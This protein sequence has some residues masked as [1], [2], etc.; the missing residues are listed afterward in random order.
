[1]RTKQLLFIALTFALSTATLQAQQLS[2]IGMAA[3]Y[4]DKLHGKRTAAGELYDKFALTAAHYNL[5]VGSRILVTR[6]DN[7][8]SVEVRVNDCCIFTKGRIV[9]LSRAAAE[10]IDLIKAGTAQVR[11]DVISV[12]DGRK[13]GAATPPAVV[14]AAAPPKAYSAEGEKLTPKGAAPPVPT[15]TYRAEELLD[16]ITSGF[17]VQ[18]GA[19]SDLSN[20]EKRVEELRKKG[21][22]NLYINVKNVN[23]KALYRVV[24]GHY[25]TAPSAAAYGKDLEKKFKIKGHVVNLQE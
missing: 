13:C 10:R 16:P 11:V 5:P 17:G 9:D 15:G 19:Y 22:T 2:E 4:A 18:T 6:L 8:Q 3:H 14:T 20:A 23:N 12:G 25:P 21:L 24:A 1:M 7:N